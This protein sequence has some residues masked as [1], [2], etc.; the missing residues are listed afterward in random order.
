M[1]DIWQDFGWDLEERELDGPEI[2]V[3]FDEIKAS[4]ELAVLVQIDKREYWIPRGKII[5]IERASRSPFDA[6][7]SLR[8][9]EWLAEAKGL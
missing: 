8:I 6:T 2:Q 4:T 5:D 9:P 1:S 7:G 3:D